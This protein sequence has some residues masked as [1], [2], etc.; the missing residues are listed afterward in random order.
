MIL[1]QILFWTMTM[2]SLIEC[3]LMSNLQTSNTIFV[4]EKEMGCPKKEDPKTPKT[5]KSNPKPSIWLNL[6]LKLVFWVPSSEVQVLHSLQL[7]S[8]WKLGDPPYW[9]E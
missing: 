5:R 9:A 6:G 1:T 3:K 8:K 4:N 2:M 7:V